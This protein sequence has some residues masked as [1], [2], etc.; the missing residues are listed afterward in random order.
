[1]EEYNAILHLMEEEGQELQLLPK[2]EISKNIFD[3]S[4]KNEKDVEEQ[5]LEP[6]LLKLDY[7]SADWVRQLSVR[8][9]RGE[10]NYPDYAIGVVNKKGEESAKLLIEAKYRI[11]SIKTLQDAYF[12]AKSYAL[13]LES[14]V[15]L[16]VSQE[17]LW[18]FEKGKRGFVFDDPNRLSWDEILHP[19]TFHNLYQKI[20]RGIIKP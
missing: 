20:G 12:Q 8:M 16:I 19:D 11:H 2:L 14:N 9:G 18:I 10:R 17:G 1:M 15:F 6:L 3:L 7:K 13:R 4:L 5:L